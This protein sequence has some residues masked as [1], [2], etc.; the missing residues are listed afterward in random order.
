MSSSQHKPAV[1]QQSGSKVSPTPADDPATEILVVFDRNYAA[2]L[3]LAYVLTRDQHDAEELVQD[4]FLELQ[5]RWRSVLNPD[6]YL[7]TALIHA[8]RRKGRQRT[9]RRRIIDENLPDVGRPSSAIDWVDNYLT[10]A[11]AKLPE[12]NR[13]AVVLAY[14]AE[15]TSTEIAEALDC[16][17]STARSL[18]RR[19]LKRL[20]EVLEA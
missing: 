18:V 20:Q 13:I 6:A 7:R 4:T 9:N 17:P 10:D 15:L 11:L 16:R 2:L 12:R 19:G 5:Q 8:A 1:V 3:R 14:Y